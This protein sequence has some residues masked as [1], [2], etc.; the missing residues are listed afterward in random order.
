MDWT[1]AVGS[2]NFGIFDLVTVGL[3]LIS[4]IAG[5]A[6]GFSRSALKMLSYV[7]CFPLALLFVDPLSTLIR[8]YVSMRQIWASLVSYIVLCLFIFL[9]IKA[10][11]NLLGLAFDTLSLGWLDST[12]GFFFCGFMAFMFIFILLELASL[13]KF[14][15]FTPL[16]ENSII[17]TK[18]FCR[19][20]PTVDRALKGAL[21][22]IR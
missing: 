17:Y 6:V 18:F 11:G 4:G 15:D 19:I 21:V 14:V 12:L 10:L 8:Q 9:L 20:F 22:A 7:L 16:K 1:L 2:F 3:V 5:I 13:Q